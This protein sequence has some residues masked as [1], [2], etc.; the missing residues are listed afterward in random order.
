MVLVLNSGEPRPTPVLVGL[1]NR[2]QAEILFGLQPGD[3]VVTGEPA[4]KPPAA[5]SGDRT[6]RPPGVGRRG[7]R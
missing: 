6:Q 5:R 7:P 4:F 1:Q 3:V 2:T